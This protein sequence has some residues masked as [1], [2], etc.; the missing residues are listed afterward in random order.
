MFEGS[1]DVLGHEREMA[2]I[3]QPHTFWPGA[4]RQSLHGADIGSRYQDLPLNIVSFLSVD[5]TMH[6]LGISEESDGQLAI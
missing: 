5:N 4:K 2:H 3:P 1:D 6:Q